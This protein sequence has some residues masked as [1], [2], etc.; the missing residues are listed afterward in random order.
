MGWGI[1]T[2]F[3]MMVDGRLVLRTL[4]LVVHLKTYFGD[5]FVRIWVLI[6]SKKYF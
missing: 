4:I 5:H 3:L 6:F 2:R 1:S